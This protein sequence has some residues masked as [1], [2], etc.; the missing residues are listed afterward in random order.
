MTSAPHCSSRAY[1]GGMSGHTVPRANAYLHGGKIR[2]S[3]GGQKGV[4]RGFGGGP[5]GVKIGVVLPELQLRL[6][7]LQRWQ[8]FPGRVEF[9][10][11]R[12]SY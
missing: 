8:H 10:S 7:L 9:S 12:R 1:A 3:K 5:E 2:G 4:Q 11:G 6:V